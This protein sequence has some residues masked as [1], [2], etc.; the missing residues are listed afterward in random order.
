[1][2]VDEAGRLA[3]LGPDE[4]VP[5]PVGVPSERFDD[6]VLLPGLVNAHTHLELTGLG[7]A[8]DEP[9]FPEWI[10][11]LRQVK[12][13]RT[14]E[15]FLAA[16]KQGIRDCW[17]AG[18][19]TVAD[20]GDSGAVIEALAELGGRGVCYH[21]VFGPHPAQLEESL[22]ELQTRAADLRRFT[23]DR[24]RLGV[25]PHAPYSVS[26]P[27]YRAVAAW[28]QMQG[29]PL[30]VHLAESAEETALVGRGQGPFAEMWRR[31]EIPVHAGEGRTP[32][33]WVDELGVLGPDT[34]CI[35]MVQATEADLRIVAERGAAAAHCPLSN[36]AHAHG[37]A[38]LA[39]MLRHGI[40]TGLGTDSV[41]SVG[42]LD[43]LA[44]AR[45]AC[46]ITGLG[47]E[48]ALGLAT[49]EAAAAI[50]WGSQIGR[51]EPGACGDI[52]LF[53]DGAGDPLEAVLQSPPCAVAT[54]VAGRAVHRVG[55]R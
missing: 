17:A 55:L 14:R 6:A 40:R 5:R 7:G 48:R 53:A 16:A 45:A 23:S 1:V 33:E 32:V 26:R 25:S 35:H 8:I 24:V 11:R 52:A 21:E 27:L 4:A 54:F 50:G 28:A 31:R 39:S 13:E 3:A 44:E 9:S 12:A 34:L 30:A 19:T 10:R 46:G 42:R 18:V 22:A 49:C 38:P 41:V 47:A 29:L 2:L 36:R 43:L 20:T 15:E 51:L 37:V